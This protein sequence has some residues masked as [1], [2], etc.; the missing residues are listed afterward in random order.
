MGKRKKEERRLRRKKEKRNNLIGK[1][2]CFFIYVVPTI[3]IGIL[4]IWLWP[5][6]LTLGI[7]IGLS[8][9]MFIV[10]CTDNDC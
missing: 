9:G 3:L 5:N 2:I 4:L 8:S 10:A 1:I 7:A 6:C